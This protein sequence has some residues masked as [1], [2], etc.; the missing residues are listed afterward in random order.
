MMND[1]NSAALAVRV[2]VCPISGGG[3][4]HRMGGP[5]PQSPIEAREGPTPPE[6]L[7]CTAGSTPGTRPPASAAHLPSE[8]PVAW[9][10]WLDKMPTHVS[11]LATGAVR[12]ARCQERRRH[13]ASFET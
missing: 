11:N 3:R 12:G 4:C 5:V 10:P 9:S 6:R 8:K 13:E 7:P 1:L 2:E